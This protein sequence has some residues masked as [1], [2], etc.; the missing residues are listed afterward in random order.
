MWGIP[1]DIIDRMKRDMSR[2]IAAKN[3]TSER[4]AVAKQ[5]VSEKQQGAPH[6]AI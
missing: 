1:I 5:S 4:N 2:D 6:V 3:K